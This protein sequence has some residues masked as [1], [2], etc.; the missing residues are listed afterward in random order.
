MVS[1]FKSGHGL[2][3]ISIIQRIKICLGYYVA[4]VMSVGFV[5]N[6]ICRHAK[7]KMNSTRRIIDEVHSFPLGNKI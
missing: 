2:E 3:T 4:V 7:C 5:V 1:S 6:E